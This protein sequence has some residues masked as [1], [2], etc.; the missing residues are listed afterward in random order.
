M[1]KIKDALLANEMCFEYTS[2]FVYLYSCCC[3]SHEVAVFVVVVV[4]V[5]R[6]GH[7]IVA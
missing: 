5:V 2:L 6:R 1:Q 3:S 4:V 7:S